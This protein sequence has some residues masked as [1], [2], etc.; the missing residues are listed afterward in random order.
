MSHLSRWPSDWRARLDCGPLLP[1]VFHPKYLIHSTSPA[2]DTTHSA[3]T[4]AEMNPSR[5]S[6]A[7]AHCAGSAAAAAGGSA[8]AV[9]GTLSEEGVAAVLGPF[10]KRQAG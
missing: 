6:A 9:A 1:Y 10:W 4:A 7:G 2:L 8:L 5:A 3:T